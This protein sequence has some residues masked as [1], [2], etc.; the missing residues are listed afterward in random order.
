MFPK[1]VCR[2]A[3][4]SHY[5]SQ[6]PTRTGSR[7][8]A[9]RRRKLQ[10][11]PFLFPAAECG[12]P[13]SFRCPRRNHTLRIHPLLCPHH[14]LLPVS[15]RRT[16][17]TGLGDAVTSECDDFSGPTPTQ[18]GQEQQGQARSSGK[19]S[20]PYLSFLLLHTPFLF[21]CLS[22]PLHPQILCHFVLNVSRNS[23]STNTFPLGY[24]PPVKAMFL[25]PSYRPG[26]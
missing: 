19:K 23:A 3:C 24:T 26:S 1:L 21:L 17:S 12:A 14:P 10:E 11:T 9:V 5:Q 15:P 4:W 20:F 25:F 16:L 8:R 13:S 6:P 18:T 7:Q 2:L 22:S